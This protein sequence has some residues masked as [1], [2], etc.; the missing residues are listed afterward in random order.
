MLERSGF[1]DV[2]FDTVFEVRKATAAGTRAFPM[3][4]AIAVRA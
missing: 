2:R 4:L 1:R 3:F